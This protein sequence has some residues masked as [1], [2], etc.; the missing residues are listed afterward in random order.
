MLATEALALIKDFEGFL[1][2]MA[3]GR[4]KPYLCP[5]S[6]ATVGW[7]TTI[8][9]DGS[10][11]KLTDPPIDRTKATEYLAWEIRKDEAA[12]DRLTTRPLPELSRG[13]MVSFIYNCG[14][15]AYRASNLRRA[16]NDGRWADV[17]KELRK[18]RIGGGRV[19]AGLVRR[20]EAEASLFMRGIRQG[21]E[22][23]VPTVPVAPPVA[24]SPAPVPDHPPRRT[25]LPEPPRTLWRRVVDW[26]LK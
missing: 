25:P 14:S 17:P 24:V 4:V 20:R 11:V 3:D 15:G 22:T 8:Y 16:V 2:L 23:S 5:A 10:R 1:R 13:A 12:F 26:V 19:L 21:L 7:G 9:P 6:V 18:W